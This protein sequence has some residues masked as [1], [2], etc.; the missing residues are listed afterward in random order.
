MALVTTTDTKVSI[1]TIVQWFES[2][3]SGLI[4]P[5]IASDTSHPMNRGCANGQMARKGIC[6]ESKSTGDAR[7]PTPRMAARLATGGVLLPRPP[8]RWRSASLAPSGT[9]EAAGST[10][11]NSIRPFT[12]QVP[13]AQIDDL[14]RRIAATRFPE[15]ETV[16][17]FSQGV[18]LEK[19]KPLVEYWGKSYDWRKAEA[20]L[21]A[22]PQFVTN[23]R[24]PRHPFHPCPLASSER[25]ADA[26]AARLAGLGVRAAQGRRPARQSHRAW[27]TRGR[28]LPSRA[29][30]VSGLWL[31]GQA[32][33]GHELGSRPD[34]S[35]VSRA[36]AASGIQA[37]TSRRAATGARSSPR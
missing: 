23:D 30:L 4:V 21:N 6:D 3:A 2:P 25:H 27:R 32:A 35:R 8:S 22:L 17:D 20:K 14:R 13:Q 34:G 37:S 18:Q 1:D 36:D 33:A 7:P 19:L 9:S 28:R 11:D 31:L 16:N 12:A 10:G 29:A 5:Y 26:H 24:R 15:R